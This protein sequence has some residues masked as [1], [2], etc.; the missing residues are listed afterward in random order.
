MRKIWSFLFSNALTLFALFAFAAAMAYATFLENDFGTLVARQAIYE[1]WWFEL[2]MFILIIN[3]VGNIYRYRL[4]R[5]EKL[6]IFLFHLAFI[7]ILIGAFVTRYSGYEGLMRIR[8]GQSSNQIISQERYLKINALWGEEKWT[9]EK[10]L[11]LT[12]LNQPDLNLEAGD[13]DDPIHINITK[14][15]PDAIQGLVDG[16]PEDEVIELVAAIDEGRSTFYLGTNRHVFLNGHEV[17][18]NNPKKNAINIE[19]AGG[20]YLIH[21]PEDFNYLVMSTQR[22]GRLAKNTTDTLQLRALYQSDHLNF[23]VSHIHQGKTLDYQ[24]TEDKK[25][26]TNAADLL[27]V[28]VYHAD[29]RQSLILAA[30]DGVFSPMQDLDIGKYNLTLSYGP[31]MVSLPFSLQLTDFQ[32]ERY[33]G[34]VSPS[35]YASEVIVEDVEESFPVRIS[36]NHVLDHRGYRFFQASYDL[37]ELGT[38][39]SVN[40]DFWGTQVTYLGYLLMGLGMLM[41]L[42]G[43]NS[44]FRQVV[45]KLRQSKMTTATGVLLLLF[46]GS[47]FAQPDSSRIEIERFAQKYIDPGH[48]AAF[49]QLL[50]QDMDGRIKPINTLASELLR[51]LTRSTSYT[52]EEEGNA[53]QLNSD[54]V[55][56]S[57]HQDPIAW[58]Y[59]PI[60]KVDAKKGCMILK[61]LALEDKP[62]LSFQD[63]LDEEG[64][65][66]LRMAVEA[67]QRKKPAERSELDHEIIKI[68]ERFNILFQ[69]LSGNYLKIFPQPDAP[70]NKWFNSDFSRAGFQEEDSL[71]VRNILS[72]YYQ[73][74]RHA[75]KSGEWSDPNDKLLYLKTFQNTMGARVIPEKSRIRAELLYNEFNV[76]NRLFPI[77]WLLGFYLLILALLRVFFRAF[78]LKTAYVLG[79]VMT[80]LASILQTINMILRWYAAGYPPWSNGYE[81]IIMVAWALLLFGFIFYRM[82]DFILPVVALFGG[83]LLFVSYLDWLNPEI[84]NLVP[85]LKSYWLKIHVAVIVSSYA[86]LALSALLGLVSLVFMIVR[87]ESFKKPI[88]ELTCINELSMTIGLF[89]LAIGTFLGGVWANESWGRYWGWDPKETWALISIIV[90]A[91]VLH[92]RLIPKLRG[93]YTFNLASIMAFFSIIMTSFGVNYYLSG[94]HSYAAGDP[95]PIPSFV[96]WTVGG[97]FLIGLFAYWR[98]EIKESSGKVPLFERQEK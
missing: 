83:T 73:D 28:D 90:Y 60:I 59:T 22:S 31:K 42:F 8:E 21:A 68:D 67:S 64:N 15:V 98:K 13:E 50:V 69:A 93:E 88:M 76:F 53:L 33:P 71:F 80:G 43:E 25:Q 81:M 6:S 12:R 10:Q 29:S 45:G 7:V 61:E 96:Y 16:A 74:I 87:N 77:Y 19:G 79:I 24:T 20:G 54:Q 46:S 40:R 58:Q 82:S 26:A 1:A 66:R 85:V 11:N 70:D 18:F 39:L 17:T 27:F 48:A 9:F 32:L 14:Y 89:M 78:W 55:F 41:T 2:L 36:M 95:L 91:I 30:L 56:L 51:K 4:L 62:M 72:V 44:R 47:A 84:T 52:L 63:L 5:K 35:S 34:S 3:F 38:V 23:V 94:L 97:L 37:D 92:M 65:Y 75:Q 49:G 57:I 86:P